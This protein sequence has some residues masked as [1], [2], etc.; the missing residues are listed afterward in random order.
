MGDLIPANVTVLETL[1]RETPDI[2][3]TIVTHLEGHYT[4]TIKSNAEY[5]M[6]TQR[7]VLRTFSTADAAIRFLNKI[8]ARN[9][10][11]CLKG[12]VR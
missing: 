5:I 9:V 12:M 3:F 7:D 6:F 10:R 4:V 11:V 8:G 1:M 2:E